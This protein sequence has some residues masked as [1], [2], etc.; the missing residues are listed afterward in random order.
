MGPI[1]GDLIYVRH[2]ECKNSA[3][4]LNI[5]W[6]I[7]ECPLCEKSIRKPDELLLTAIPT[8]FDPLASCAVLLKPSSGT[9]EKYV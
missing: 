3:I 4:G 8:P 1:D 9:F 2:T 5:H 6:P 7:L